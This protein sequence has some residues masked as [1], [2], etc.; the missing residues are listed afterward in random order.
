M[1]LGSY[2]GDVLTVIPV[3]IVSPFTELKKE[4]LISGLLFPPPRPNHPSTASQNTFYHRP[5]V[6][7]KNV[8][9]SDVLLQELVILTSF[10]FWGTGS[11]W[12][13]SAIS[14]AWNLRQHLPRRM[15]PLVSL[16][17][18]VYLSILKKELPKLLAFSSGA[19]NQPSLHNIVMY[20]CCLF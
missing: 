15:A 8:R 20:T 10:L 11:C 16:Q 7:V 5:S 2:C 14:L 19:T 17:K 18:K 9:S 12:Y 6:I 4:D 1:Y 13:Q 3:T